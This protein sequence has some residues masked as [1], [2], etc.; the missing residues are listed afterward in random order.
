MQQ[1][2]EP[3]QRSHETPVSPEDKSADREEQ[4][5]PNV[6]LPHRYSTLLSKVFKC[7]V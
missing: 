5:P 4:D 3:M 1:R 2:A 7:I 6:A